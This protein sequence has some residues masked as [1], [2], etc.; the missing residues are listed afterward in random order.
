MALENIE[1]L[2]SLPTTVGILIWLVELLIVYNK[3]CS[4]VRS[5]QTDNITADY[6]LK[7]YG[8]FMRNKK[9][10]GQRQAVVDII[11][12][13]K[14]ETDIKIDGLID[15]MKN[16]TKKKKLK[17]QLETD[18]KAKEKEVTQLYNNVKELRQKAALLP[19]RSPTPSPER[20]AQLPPNYPSPPRVK[21]SST[22]NPL[23]DIT[24]N[25]EDPLKDI[26]N[27]YEP[28]TTTT[29]ELLSIMDRGISDLKEKFMQAADDCEEELAAAEN[30]MNEDYER[31]QNLL[32]Q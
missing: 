9:Y 6:C 15:E 7:A 19:K 25:S 11:K 30:D 2:T 1:S 5:I 17:K 16:L 27:L 8:K 24:N 13:K 10:S 26:E 22:R 29:H 23:L 4:R 21:F 28:L 3:E 14:N 18:I 20:P 12:N 31:F 32:K